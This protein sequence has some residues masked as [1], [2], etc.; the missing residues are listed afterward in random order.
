MY[1]K[2]FNCG[3]LV[4]GYDKNVCRWRYWGLELGTTA[5]LNTPP[6]WPAVAL[7]GR[8]K[9]RKRK[10]NKASRL[11]AILFHPEHLRDHRVSG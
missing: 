10:T 11:P 3:V 4:Q 6:A 5:P 2:I 7:A 9:D 8:M 1:K